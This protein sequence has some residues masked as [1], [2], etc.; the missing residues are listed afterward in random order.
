[1][2]ISYCEEIY[3][4]IFQKIAV[5]SLNVEYYDIIFINKTMYESVCSNI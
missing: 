3:V 1:M 5:N 4:I 2:S